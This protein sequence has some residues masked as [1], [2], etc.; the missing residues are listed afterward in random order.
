[1]SKNVLIVL[2][3]MLLFSWT[4]SAGDLVEINKSTVPSVDFKDGKLS[5]TV[6]IGP[7]YNHRDVADTMSYTDA[8]GS[9]F[10]QSPGDAM[11]VAFQM[12]ADGI[13]KG[14]NVPVNEWGTGDQQLTVSLYELTY[15]YGLDANGDPIRYPLTSVDGNG[16]IGGYDMMA[17]SGAMVFDGDVYTPPG[18]APECAGGAANVADYAAD[19]LGQVDSPFGPPGLPLQGLI[20]PDGFTAPTLDPANNPDNSD[21]VSANWIATADFG[22]EPVVTGGTW[23]GVLVFF[24]G[25]GGGADEPC[26][27]WYADGDPLGLND[28]YV[29]LKFYA[30]CGG[31]SGSG[32]WHIRHWVFGFDLAVLLTGDRGPTYGDEASLVTTVSTD[33]IPYDIDIFDDNPSGGSAGVASAV[34][35]YQLDSVTAT[36][37]DLAMTAT[38]DNYAVSIPG[39]VAGTMVYYWVEATDV[40]GNATTTPKK[41]YY[42]FL[43]RPGKILLFN[44]TDPLYGNILYV[45]YCY[46]EWGTTVAFD[47]WASDYGNITEALVNN[48]DVILEVTE[49]GADFDTDP[50]LQPWFALGDKVYVVEGDEWLGARYGWPSASMDIPA[51]DFAEDIGI[52]HYYPDVNNAATSV[53]RLF[54][55]AAD[56]VSGALATFLTDSSCVL[57]YDP[58][59]DPGHS[60]WLDGIDAGTGAVVAFTGH[61]GEVDTLG[62]SSGTTT[63]TTGIY[64]TYGTSKAAFFAFDIMSLYARNYTSGD[65][66][67]VGAWDYDYYHVSPF[68]MA[69]R[70]AGVEYVGVDDPQSTTPSQFT[71]KGNYPNPFNP[72]TNISYS[73]D[74]TSDVNVTVYSLLG[75]EIATLH[76]G[77]QKAGV[78][79]VE[80]SGISDLG[81]TVASGMYLYRITSDGRALTGKMLLL[82]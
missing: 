71:L 53:S 76:S 77:V 20:W 27:F 48:Y 43:S 45:P 62:V 41:S 23:V 33:A 18:T 9:A 67:W 6:V 24:S 26:A 17:D 35:H 56:D 55:V 66:Y 19:P 37:N 42:I 40:G 64:G 31:T 22:T 58:Q 75:Q 3:I 47:I 32:G 39:Q 44:N 79:T 29:A 8:W 81:N 15:P 2:S 59:Y 5:R 49:A 38:G 68:R 10:I 12:P 1:M 73:L 51:G 80:W 36:V 13:I 4:L 72:I 61:D 14:V 82:K 50:V 74:I 63:Y 65:A 70:W 52:I 16:W 78:H 69:L 30:G 46:Y 21:E 60:N 28:P 7:S 57:D 25:A 54:P 11:I 34:L